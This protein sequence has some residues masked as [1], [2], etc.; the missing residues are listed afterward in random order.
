M[1][2]LNRRSRTAKAGGR[3]VCAEGQPLGLAV[4]VAFERPADAA[5]QRELDLRY[6]GQGYELRTPLD[7]LARGALTPAAMAAARARFDERHAR[8]HGHAA[9]DR[10]VEVVS[11]RVRVRVASPK[12]AARAEAAPQTPRPVGSAEKGARQVFFDPAAPVRATVYERD[13]LDVGVRVHGP[14]IVE[15]FDATTVVPP[16]WS[17]QVDDYRNLVLERAGG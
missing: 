5:F 13:R 10:P 4:E 16:G 6:T 9:S 12:Y 11:Y 8:A 14:C 17:A 2:S 3:A 15:Q 7:G 1:P